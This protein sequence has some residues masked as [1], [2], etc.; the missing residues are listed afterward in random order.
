MNN[1]EVLMHEVEGF[2]K[3]T[4]NKALFQYIK[5]NPNMKTMVVLMDK[6]DTDVIARETSVTERSR[7]ACGM[8]L[9][10]SIPVISK[11]QK[12]VSKLVNKPLENFESLHIVKYEVGGEYKP[13]VDS[14]LEGKEYSKIETFRGGQRQFSA[15]FYL[16]DDFEGGETDFPNLQVTVVPKKNKLII[17]KNI[18]ENGS[19]DQSSNHAGLPVTKGTK[20]IG[21]WWIRVNKWEPDKGID[22]NSLISASKVLEPYRFQHQYPTY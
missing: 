13:H 4:E 22:H 8:W 14:F 2:I 17:W 19:P 11:I 10:N 9:D 15:L 16:N 5:E 7:K 21:I 12:R 18:T 3:P 1:K 6:N 20:Y